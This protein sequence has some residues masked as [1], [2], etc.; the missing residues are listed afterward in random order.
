M[1]TKQR[2][3]GITGTA[4]ASDA[5]K[6]GTTVS[7][8]KPDLSGA[9]RAKYRSLVESIREAIASG[10]LADDERLPAQ[11]AMAKLLGVNVA[12]VTK[13]ISEAGRLGLVVTRPGGGTRVVG[14]KRAASATADEMRGI[15]D[16]S[17]NIPPVAL[18]KP[19]LDDI[20]ATLAQLRHSEQLFNYA[21][22]GGAGRDRD[23]GGHWISARGLKPAPERLIVTQGAHEGLFAALTA[24]IQPGDTVLCENL[25]Y[26]GIRRLGELCRVT[27]V[28]IATDDGGMQP[29][30]LADACAKYS[31]K[32]IVCTPVTLNPTTATQNLER[33]QAI[34]AIARRN[35]VTIIEDDIYGS[36]AG[37]DTPPLAAL[38][39]EGVIYVCG[40]SKC[41]A[42]GLRVGY[43][44]APA[45]LMS[46]LRDALVLLSWTAPS[47]HGAVATEM[48]NSGLAQ[49][50]A[51]LHR[52]EALRRMALAKGILGKGLVAGPAATYHAWLPLPS[53][54]LERDAVA[55]FQR[56][57]ILVSPA[58]HFVVG[59]RNAPAAVRISLGATADAGILERALRTIADVLDRE[60]T[61]LNSVV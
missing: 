11:R 44:S 54:W 14:A 37:D 61:G 40:L 27:L 18:V 59:N 26:T 10:E 58:G 45:R 4:A 39:P 23:A 57:G 56:H 60:S 49:A 19:I 55:S 2:R 46:R 6:A 48:I 43:L 15:V 16:L 41:V 35:S 31:P 20:M 30:A 36:I 5:R 34:L 12:T 33:R 25:N 32:A 42:P 28:G 29:K 13:A 53:A 7:R 52:D 47:L 3:V 8:W 51:R 22:L 24:A 50:C 1:K 21:P 38:W 17:I 9:G